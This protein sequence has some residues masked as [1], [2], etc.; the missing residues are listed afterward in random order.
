V[1]LTSQQRGAKPHIYRAN[2]NIRYTKET[3]IEAVKRC[4]SWAEVCKYFGVK[5]SGGSQIN[6]KRRS[7]FFGIDYSHFPGKA[8]LRGT[9]YNRVPIE[10]YLSNELPV[11]SHKLKLRLIKD[12]IKEY[13]CENCGL[14]EWMGRPISLE[15][16]HI[17]GNHFNNLLINIKILCPNC[18]AFCDHNINSET[19]ITIKRY[20]KPKVPKQN[21]CD[22]GH[23]ITRRAKYCVSCSHKHQQK[24]N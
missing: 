18:H 14:I 24:I 8:H 6:Y 12:G 20:K 15:L 21:Y 22:C 11:K 23:P 16:H 5:V 4:K 7:E 3:L 17:D 1:K 2:M 10:R 19:G 13:K 9:Y